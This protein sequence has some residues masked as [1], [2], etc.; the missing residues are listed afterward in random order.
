M[1]Y[2]NSPV[3]LSSSIVFLKMLRII[4]LAVFCAA[5]ATAFNVTFIPEPTLVNKIS[6]EPQK[7]TCS[8]AKETPNEVHITSIVISRTSP[9]SSANETF[10]LITSFSPAHATDTNDTTVTVSGDVTGSQDEFLKVVWNNPA[11][12]V[13]GKY[14]CEVFGVDEIGRPASFTTGAVVSAPVL[15]L[16][17]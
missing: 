14:F 13:E 7:L 10:A 5:T 9:V 6:G 8:V 11:E 2:H 16:D 4:I 12:T 17:D 1:G 3:L 15:K